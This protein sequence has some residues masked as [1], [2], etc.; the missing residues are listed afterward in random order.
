MLCSRWKVM[1]MIIYQLS[2]LIKLK[3]LIYRIVVCADKQLL[4]PSNKIKINLSLILYHF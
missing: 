2:G 3:S 4:T 1:L